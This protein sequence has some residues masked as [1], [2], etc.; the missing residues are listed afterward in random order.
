MSGGNGRVGDINIAT[1]GQLAMLPGIEDAYA[2]KII[3]GRP[4][5]ARTS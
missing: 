1:K 5:K 3:A 4:Y 2:E